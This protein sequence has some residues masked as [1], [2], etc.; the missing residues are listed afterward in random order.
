MTHAKEL[1]SDGKTGNIAAG[2]GVLDWNYYFDTLAQMNFRG[3]MV[4]HGLAECD[5]AESVRFLRAKLCD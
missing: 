5:V 3:P 1:S 4:M 2:R